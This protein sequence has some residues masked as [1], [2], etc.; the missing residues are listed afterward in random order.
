MQSCK[1]KGREVCIAIIVDFALI[2][3]K[4]KKGDNRNGTFNGNRAV[5]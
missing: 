2:T 5:D 1:L 4:F 3:N